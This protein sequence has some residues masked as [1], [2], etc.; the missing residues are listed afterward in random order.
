[1]R[2]CLSAS[3]KSETA[4]RGVGGI[5]IDDHQRLY[6]AGAHIAYQ[7][8]ERSRICGARYRLE[9]FQELPGAL[10]RIVDA[11]DPN[12]GTGITEWT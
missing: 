5:A 1:M 3:A 7:L 10:Q 9:E 8:L 2:T 6:L 12:S 4:W 11:S